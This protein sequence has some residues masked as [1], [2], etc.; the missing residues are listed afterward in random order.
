M[1]LLIPALLSLLKGQKEP[2]NNTSSNALSKQLDILGIAHI[3]TRDP[4]GLL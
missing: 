4:G 2:G 1:P 3:V